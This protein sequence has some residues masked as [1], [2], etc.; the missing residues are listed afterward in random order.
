M[1]AAPG[2]ALPVGTTL[3]TYTNSDGVMVSQAGVGSVEPIATGRIFVDERGSQTG[4]A[5][6][7]TSNQTTNIALT[8]RSASGQ[9]QARKPL[10]LEAGHHLPTFVFQQFESLPTDFTGSLTFESDQKIAAVTLKLTINERNEQ[11]L[12]TLPVADMTWPPSATSVVFPQIAIGGGFSTR[13]IVINSIA[14]SVVTGKL[15][16]YQSSGNS[17][18]IPLAGTGTIGSSDGSSKTAAF[19]RPQGIALDNRGNLWVADSGNHTIRRI[20]L[21]AGTVE[22]IAG[23]AGAAGA[24]DGLRDQARFNTPTGV[25]IEL[26]TT[27]QALDRELKGLPPPPVSL[28]VADS[29]NELVRRVKETGALETIRSGQSSPSTTPLR[30]GRYSAAAGAPLTFKSPIGIAVDSSGNIYVSEA[31]TGRV[32]VVLPNSAAIALAQEGTFILCC[33]Y[34]PQPAPA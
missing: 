5:L 15:S 10:T 24:V 17:M 29:G 32:R 6:V 30:S 31:D 34:V 12:T 13:L 25:A 16:F 26:E 8:L 11:I 28:L 18:S 4:I 14:S 33:I 1:T 22:T 21:A 2:T 3:F 9:L 7:N 27:A 23:K 20:K 19:F